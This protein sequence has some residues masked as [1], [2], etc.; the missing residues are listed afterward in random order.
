LTG[1]PMAGFWETALS[2]MPSSVSYV[3]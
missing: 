2:Y 1:C 3:R